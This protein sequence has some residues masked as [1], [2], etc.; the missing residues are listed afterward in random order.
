MTLSC[1]P[2]QGTLEKL[3]KSHEAIISDCCGRKYIKMCVIYENALV[4]SAIDHDV[5][6]IFAIQGWICS[7][8]LLWPYKTCKLVIPS[9]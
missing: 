8:E 2:L 7:C 1:P 6:L 9:K 3:T 5:G 4:R